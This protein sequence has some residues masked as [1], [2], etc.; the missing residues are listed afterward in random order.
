MIKKLLS[1]I[2]CLFLLTSIC[3][4]YTSLELKNYIGQNV[5]IRIYNPILNAPSPYYTFGAIVIQIFSKGGKD[6][7][8]LKIGN[9]YLEMPIQAIVD[10][11]QTNTIER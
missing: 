10:I 2:I 4:A 1:I 7:L 5:I 3:F 9:E 6:Y 8:T 11:K